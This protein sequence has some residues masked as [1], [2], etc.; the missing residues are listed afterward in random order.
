[1]KKQNLF[2]F[3]ILFLSLLLLPTV[4]G[5]TEDGF[6]TYPSGNVELFQFCLEDKNTLC[7][8]GTTCNI[9]SLLDPSI[10]E[11]QLLSNASMTRK[12]DGIYNYSLSLTTLGDYTMKTVCTNTTLLT[13]SV[14]KVRIVDQL[15]TDKISTINVTLENLTLEGIANEIW[16]FTL[17]SNLSA[18]ITLTNILT[19][20]KGLPDLAMI[21][22]TLVM[23]GV[24]FFAGFR[25]KGSK[26]TRMND[27]GEMIID[28]TPMN[29][30]SYLL[31]IGG[32]LGLLL[33]LNIARAS[34]EAANASADLLNMINTAYTLGAWIFF[35]SLF[36]F[37]LIIIVNLINSRNVRKQM[38]EDGDL[39]ED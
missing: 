20:T 38:I 30:L 27:K 17:G 29:P 3:S 39:D 8:S 19:N 35:V 15:L 31:F 21:L 12:S 11:V 4:Q 28:R 6:I 16:Q 13:R 18:N 7:S 36:L 24:F 1:M 33:S 9:S 14:Q 2:L 5:A 23:A 10:P 26:T 37:L 25:S 22:S 34:A 32:F